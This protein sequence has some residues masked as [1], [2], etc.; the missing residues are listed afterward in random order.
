MNRRAE[1][2]GGEGEERRDGHY[3]TPKET[4]ETRNKAS[5]Q[6]ICTNPRIH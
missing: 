2:E 5:K 3:A 1:E 4:K 6:G